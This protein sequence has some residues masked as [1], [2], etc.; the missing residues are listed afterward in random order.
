M[1]SLSKT[2]TRLKAFIFFTTC[3]SISTSG[4]AQAQRLELTAELP[5]SAN[6]CLANP[7]DPDSGPLLAEGAP[8]CAAELRI[9]SGRGRLRLGIATARILPGRGIASNPVGKA[10][11]ADVSEPGAPAFDCSQTLAEDPIY[12]RCVV[13][14]NVGS[15]DPVVAGGLPR[16]VNEAACILR[17]PITVEVRNP[18]DPVPANRVK[19]SE[20]V[21]VVECLVYA[22]AG[23]EVDG[24]DDATQGEPVN[25]CTV[26]AGLRVD[27]RSGNL[28]N[29][30]FAATEGWRVIIRQNVA[31]PD[32]N[33]NSNVRDNVVSPTN[34]RLE[35]DLLG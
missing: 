29:P 13:E 33:G 17:R 35:E 3:F 31:N 34:V 11:C 26:D 7:A 27:D 20:I 6:A 24:R 18:R 5:D 12:S 4:S 22:G 14:L 30:L 25:V 9:E 1:P 19:F 8:L 28:S 10:R 15:G 23:T 2:I 32:I 21:R 16:V